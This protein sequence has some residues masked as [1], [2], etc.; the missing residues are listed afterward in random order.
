KGELSALRAESER[1]TVESASLRRR[2][3]AAEEGAKELRVLKERVKELERLQSESAETAPAKPAGVGPAPED[4]AEARRR[5]VELS[6]LLFERGELN[7][8]RAVALSASRL[9]ADDAATLYRIAYCT[10]A[11]GQFEEAGQWYERAREALQAQPD[12]DEEL[13]K[14]C[15][16][17]HG[18]ALAKLGKADDAERLYRDALELDAGYAPAY[19]NLGLLC[20][21]DPGRAEEAIQAFRSHIAH[22]GS[23][24]VAAR[25]CIMALQARSEPEAADQ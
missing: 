15:L 20:E 1:L 12:P 8:A 22:G 6:Q 2:L 17:N 23:R 3:A 25:N 4:V 24:S 16:N 11:T 10:A 5:L 9:G 14:K 18:A 7:A 21:G 19:F 13:L